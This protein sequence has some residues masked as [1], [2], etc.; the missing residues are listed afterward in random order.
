M[1]GDNNKKPNSS[2]IIFRHVNKNI[3]ITLIK[4]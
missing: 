3:K 1:K 4:L 2:Y